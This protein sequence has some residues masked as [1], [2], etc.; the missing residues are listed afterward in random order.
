[1]S[2]MGDKM[3]TNRVP[4]SMIRHQCAKKVDSTCADTP[5]PISWSCELLRTN[6]DG[7]FPVSTEISLRGCMS[8]PMEIVEEKHHRGS[9]F[10]VR[11]PLDNALAVSGDVKSDLYSAFFA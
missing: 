4:I 7:D 1:M 8:E 9:T 10:Y 5:I 2:T 6:L 3:L 11:R